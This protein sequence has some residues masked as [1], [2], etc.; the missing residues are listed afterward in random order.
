VFKSIGKIFGSMDLSAL[1]IGSYEPRW[2]MKHQHI[3]PEDAIQ[4][5]KD[6]N[7]KRSVA[8]HWGTFMLSD[9]YYLAPP[10][11][12]EKALEKENDV[13]FDAIKFGTTIVV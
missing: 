2:F 3:D 6:V 8:I 7:S 5:H 4:I 13:R 9:E 10:K 12:L 11:K 1:P